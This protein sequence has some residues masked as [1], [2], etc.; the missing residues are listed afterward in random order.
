MAQNSNRFFLE[1]N[2]SWAIS[3]TAVYLNIIQENKER[4]NIDEMKIKD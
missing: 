3:R 2:F 1:F 4:T